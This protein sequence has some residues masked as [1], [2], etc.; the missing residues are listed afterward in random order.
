[1]QKIVPFL[2]FDNQLEEALDFYT[3]IFKNSKVVDVRRYEDAGPDLESTVLAATFQLD[4]VEFM[5]MN[6]GP[7]YTFSPATSFY[8][9]CETQGECDELWEKLLEGGEADRLSPRSSSHCSPT[10]TPRRSIA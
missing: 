6:G 4:G 5:G 2:W 9:K 3:S 8:V 10:R 1:M 7:L